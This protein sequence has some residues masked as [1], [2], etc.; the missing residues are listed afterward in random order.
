MTVRVARFAE[1]DTATLYALLRLR[2]DVFV[3]EQQCPYPEL[4]GRDTDPGTHHLWITGDAE[5]PDAGKPEPLAYLR[6]LAEPGGVPRIGRVVVAK[7][8]R[9]GGHAA[10]LMERALDL[11]G[12]GPCVLDAQSYL[13][14][15]YARYG[16]TPAGPEYVE[17]G[18]AH[19]PMRRA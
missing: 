2:V 9:G 8:A 10:R 6:L 14:D 3:V 1:L 7:G 15:F 13:V 5:T 18:I 11:V 16:F 17:D 4:D 19:V 12:A